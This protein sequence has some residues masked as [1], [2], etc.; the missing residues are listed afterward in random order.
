MLFINIA[1]VKEEMF[2]EIVLPEEQISMP[3]RSS[4][5]SQLLEETLYQPSNP[6]LDYAKFDGEVCCCFSLHER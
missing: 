1:S 3:T 5:L 4:Q 6:Y 2:Q